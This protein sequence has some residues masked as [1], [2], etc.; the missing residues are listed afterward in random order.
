MIGLK[1]CMEMEIK[2]KI[3]YTVSIVQINK[4]NNE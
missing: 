2:R 3:N 1:I 4:R